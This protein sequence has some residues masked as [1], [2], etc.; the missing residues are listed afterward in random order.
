MADDTPAPEI[1]PEL[2]DGLNRQQRLFVREYLVDLNATSAA[3]RA[4][5]SERN[6][7]SLG[8]QLLQKAPV[9]I[10]VQLALA[11]REKRLE[12]SADWVLMRLR[13]VVERAMEAVPV[14]DRKG[15]PIEGQ[16]TFDSAG[17]N[18]A[19]ELIGKHLAMFGGKGAK[20][21]D[22]GHYRWSPMIGAAHG[23]RKEG[24]N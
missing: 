10:A 1:E 14:L 18:R 12:L 23:Q 13:E 9:L 8:Y 5:Y 3:I 15:K 17:A 19:L 11:E 7:S 4:G 21:P 20:D 22:A 2:G 6:A 16:W 24:V